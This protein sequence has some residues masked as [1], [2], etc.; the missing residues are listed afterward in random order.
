[1]INIAEVKQLREQTGMGIL[2]IKEAL[3]EAGGDQAKALAILK[4]KGAQILEKK[5]AR[6]TSQGLI[7]VYSHQDRI[8]VL[9]EVNCETDFVARNPEFKEFVHDLSLQISS[10]NPDNI[11]TFLEQEF[12]KDPARRIKDLLQDLAAK[13]G[14]NIVVKR[15]VRFELGDN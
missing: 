11:E 3:K 13:L 9:V 2:D 5:S 7:N 8:G 12:I 4:N 6:K 14:E 1:M 10:M 15:F